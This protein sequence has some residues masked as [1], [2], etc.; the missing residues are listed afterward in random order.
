MSPSSSLWFLHWP[1]KSLLLDF[2][3]GSVSY[4]SFTAVAWVQSLAWELPQPVNVAKLKKKSFFIH[5]FISTHSVFHVTLRVI[6]LKLKLDLFMSLWFY[7]HN[8]SQ[9]TS[10]LNKALQNLPSP[11]NLSSVPSPASLTS[12]IPATLVI[13]FFE[14]VESFPASGPLYPLLFDPAMLFLGY[15][16]GFC[17]QPCWKYWSL[18]TWWLLTSFFPHILSTFCHFPYYIFICICVLFPVFLQKWLSI[19]KTGIFFPI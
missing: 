4:S 6:F 12:I 17:L 19:V 13:F 16:N 8:K 11:E 9:R 14:Y 18:I 7:S 5:V 3:C 15:I 2:L 1:L 10:I